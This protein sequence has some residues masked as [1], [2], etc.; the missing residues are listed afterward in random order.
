MC[1]IVGYVGSEDCVP[2]LLSGLKRLEYRGYD[3][4]GLAVIGSAGLRVIKNE[5]KVAGLQAR[6]PAS[7]ISG[8]IGIGHTRW[9]T[10]GRPSEENSHPHTSCGG[11]IA[12][13]HNGIIENYL[14]IKE[15]LLAAGHIFRSETDSEVVAH[16]VEEKFAQAPGADSDARFFEAV[17]LAVRE[18]EGAFAIAVVCDA[19]PGLFIGARRHSPLVAGIGDGEA[20]LA[21]DVPAFMEHTRK[22]VFLKDGEIAVLTAGKVKIFDM[23]GKPVPVKANVIKWDRAMAGKGGYKHFML[24]EIYDQPLSVE[25]TLLGRLTLDEATLKGEF[26]LDYKAARAIT[27]IHI[28][29]CGTAYHAGLVAK[30]AIEHFARIAADID[31]AS[32]FRYREP[33]LAAGTLILSVSQSG[34]TADTL[35]AVRTCRA[36]GFKSLAICNVLGSTLT[37][38][39]DF[40]C[41]THCG[42]EISVASTKAFTAQLAAL[43]ALALQ[44]GRARGALPGPEGEALAAEL[45]RLPRLMEKT[46]SLDKNIAEVARKICRKG[47]Y[48]FLGRN[49][50]FPIALE[51]A[52]KLKE[53]SYV[54]AEAFAGGEMKHGP[55]AIIDEGMPVF[56]IA[57]HAA[58]FDKMLSNLHEAVARGARVIGIMTE[59]I[60]A[61]GQLA[62]RF[63]VPK[64]NEYFSPLLTV[65][66]LQFFAYHIAVLRGCEIDQPRNLAKSVTVE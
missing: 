49:S 12:V 56:G 15:R 47:S 44:L 26:G 23:D 62:A 46:V 27:R 50:N 28:V 7:G 29:A 52:L 21:S 30:Y 64:V 58:T 51:G 11:D 24:K 25:E 65:I 6:L 41:Y 34:E 57:V 13:V 63:D 10:H 59:G 60:P 38:E 3:S 5:G 53:V 18:L 31:V 1:G 20:F 36:A 4:A 33:V 54:H 37:R 22:A 40:T 19:C 2:V 14:Q 55:I 66:P 39:S 48:L 8:S 35:A 43:L 45:M 61:G 9:A 42:P 17:R 16:L 32:E